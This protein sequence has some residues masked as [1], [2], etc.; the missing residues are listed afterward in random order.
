MQRRPAALFSERCLCVRCQSVHLCFRGRHGWMGT[1]KSGAGVI[2]DCWGAKMEGNMRCDR[3]KKDCELDMDQ[4]PFIVCWV[5]LI[6]SSTF[7]FRSCLSYFLVVCFCHLLRYWNGLS[8]LFLILA[9]LCGTAKKTKT[10]FLILRK[11]NQGVKKLRLVLLINVYKRTPLGISVFLS[12]Y[13]K[14]LWVSTRLRR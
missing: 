6:L 14:G 9:V 4:P 13:F 2:L 11:H 10:L 8:Y 1:A 7:H 5:E 12:I 3:S